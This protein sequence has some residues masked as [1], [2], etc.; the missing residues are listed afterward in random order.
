MLAG[1]GF[2]AQRVF[3]KY[4]QILVDED[5]I[6]ICGERFKGEFFIGSLGYANEAALM[7]NGASLAL[8]RPLFR[9]LFSFFR[10][11]LALLLLRHRASSRVEPFLRNLSDFLVVF[12]PTRRL[13]GLSHDQFPQSSLF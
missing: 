12:R 8:K 1:A 10:A 5:V 13:A 9:S 4:D 2:V 3:G 7:K 11:K 6:E